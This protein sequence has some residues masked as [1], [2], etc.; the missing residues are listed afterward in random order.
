MRERNQLVGTKTTSLF[1]V[2]LAISLHLASP[3]FFEGYNS[4]CQQYHF[5]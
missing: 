5:A 3:P 2:T 4:V 1:L